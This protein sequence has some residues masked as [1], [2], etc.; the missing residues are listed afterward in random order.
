M[1]KAASSLAGCIGSDSSKVKKIE[2]NRTLSVSPMVSVSPEDFSQPV[3]PGAAA[4]RAGRVAASL[5]GR[6][7][8]GQEES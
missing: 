6:R 3:V 4:L 5:G 7:M 8:G 1:A 2:I